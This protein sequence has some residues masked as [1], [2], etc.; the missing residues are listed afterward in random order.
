MAIFLT[1]NKVQIF[2]D[3]STGSEIKATAMMVRIKRGRPRRVIIGKDKSILAILTT[4]I[5]E[6]KY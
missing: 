3:H 6:V 5:K 4:F 1:S 2:R